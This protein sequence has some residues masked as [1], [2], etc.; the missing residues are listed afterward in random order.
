M[1][2]RMSQRSSEDLVRFLEGADRNRLMD[3]SAHML[4]RVEAFV[5]LHYR[6]NVYDQRMPY[7]C[8]QLVFGDAPPPKQWGAGMFKDAP[9][10]PMLHD[11][12]RARQH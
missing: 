9:E 3:N 8:W 12:A 1:Q 5:H 4:F 7:M 11:V 10:V 2:R 6:M